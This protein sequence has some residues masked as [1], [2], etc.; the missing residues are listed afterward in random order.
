MEVF[1]IEWLKKCVGND[2]NLKSRNA[3]DIEVPFEFTAKDFLKFAEY[4]LSSECDHHVVNALSNIKRAI[5]CQTDSLL[6][7]LGLFEKSK[8]QN[9]SFPQKIECLNKVG[10]ISP[11]ILR[12]I[13]QRRN[14]LEHEYKKPEKVQMEDALDVAKLFIAYTNKFL[15]N[16]V[17]ELRLF[18]YKQFE[19]DFRATLHYKEGRIFFS[20]PEIVNGNGEKSLK[21][22][23]GFIYHEVTADSEE[24]L[25]Y[26][27]W[28][29][30]LHQLNP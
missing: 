17:T 9:W 15:F 2:E 21:E 30:S 18:A 3:V 19:E 16:A 25:D 29:V 24:Y 14:L 28:F 12:R 27:K 5:N 1:S 11:T 10:I 20:K 22:R 7:G 13:N 8:K 6:F 23:I 4:D 26:L